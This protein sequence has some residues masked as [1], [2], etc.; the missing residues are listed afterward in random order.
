MQSAVR[1]RGNKDQKSDGILLWCSKKSETDISG[2]PLKYL[3]GIWYFFALFF[4]V[5]L[6][7]TRIA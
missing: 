7:M 1:E 6:S 2:T 3:M 5:L 4:A